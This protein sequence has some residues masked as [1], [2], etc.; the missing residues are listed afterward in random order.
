MH[1]M[2]MAHVLRMHMMCMAHVLRMHMM[3]SDE[4]ALRYASYSVSRSRALSAPT[5]REASTLITGFRLYARLNA[6]K[7][8]ALLTSAAQADVRSVAVASL[9]PLSDELALRQ[10]LGLSLTDAERADGD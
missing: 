8:H 6:D 5:T 10:L 7:Y 4:L 1:M 9:P 3:L 2:C